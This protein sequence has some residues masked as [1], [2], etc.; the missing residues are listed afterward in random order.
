MPEHRIGIIK[1]KLCIYFGLGSDSIELLEVI[2]IILSFLGSNIIIDYV[3]DSRQTH[4]G[5]ARVANDQSKH[6]T[7]HVE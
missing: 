7:Q 2:T 5:K 1:T 4:R 3:T 6:V